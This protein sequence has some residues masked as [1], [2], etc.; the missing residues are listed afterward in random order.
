VQACQG[1]AAVTRSIAV[2]LNAGSGIGRREGV[3]D[4]VAELCRAAGPM[5]L[6]AARDV[7]ELCRAV[8]AALANG[9]DAIVAGGGDGTLSRVAGYL[10]GTQ[11]PLGILPL[12]TLNHFARDLGI[13]LEL[14][15]A[16]AVA[17]KGH[18]ERFDVGEV[19]GRVF[20]NNASLGL[21]PLIVRLRQQHPTRGFAK[22]AVAVW[23]TLRELRRHREITVRIKT[24]DQVVVHRT[25]VVFVGNNEYQ[26]VGLGTGTRSSLRDGRLAIYIVEA[27][28][29][30][31]L[32]RLAWRM[33]RGR[34]EERELEVLLTDAATIEPTASIVQLALDGE[35]DTFTSPLMFRVRPGALRVLVPRGETPANGSP[36]RAA[37]GDEP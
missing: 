19:N 37:G 14:D 15:V 11:V 10:A 18:S 20:L 21:Y 34:P 3:Q 23:A 16:M 13:P 36:I 27:G 29:R 32:L 30:R 6:T 9:A 1:E 28:G 31:H 5:Q 24:D 12:G 8:E 17:L 26:T 4:R 7:Q 2:V 25:P 33:L 22:W 35:V